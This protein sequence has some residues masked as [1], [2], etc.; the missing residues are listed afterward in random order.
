MSFEHEWRTKEQKDAS[1][2]K[3]RDE[4]GRLTKCHEEASMTDRA[5]REAMSDIKRRVLLFRELGII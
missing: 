2:K 4:L 5:V 1:K 3:L